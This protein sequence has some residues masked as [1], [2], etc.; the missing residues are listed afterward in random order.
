M[1]IALSI[2]WQGQPLK[3]DSDL[4]PGVPTGGIHNAQYYFLTGI[5]VLILIGIFFAAYQI[6]IGGL[7]IIASRG[8]KQILQQSREKIIYAL[9]GIAVM[10]FSIFL[11]NI[12]G[13]LLGVNLLSFRP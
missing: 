13:G 10:F 4:P 3:I 8:D 5:E 9:I 11:L 7:N 1:K 2:P 6:I 12:I